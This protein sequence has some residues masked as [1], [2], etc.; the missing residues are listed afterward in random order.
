MYYPNISEAFPSNAKN[1]SEAEAL[2]YQ[3]DGH[4]SASLVDRAKIEHWPSLASAA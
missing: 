2:I 3:S 4:G 1:L